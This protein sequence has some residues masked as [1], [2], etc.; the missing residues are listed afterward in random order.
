M[1]TKE[2]LKGI[3]PILFQVAMLVCNKNNLKVWP[4]KWFVIYNYDTVQQSYHGSVGSSKTMMVPSP[5]TLDTTIV[6]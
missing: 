4:F 5:S 1:Q 6:P 2:E 3:T